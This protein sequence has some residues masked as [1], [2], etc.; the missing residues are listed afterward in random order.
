MVHGKVLAIKGLMTFGIL[1]LILGLMFSMSLTNVLITT[2]ALTVISY[3]VG[4]LY[5]LPKTNNVIASL[6][7]IGIAFLVIW[8]LSMGIS[9]LGIGTLA[10]GAIIASVV[11]AVG[12]FFF[13]DYLL[14]NYIGFDRKYTYSPNH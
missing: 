2:I 12:E 3:L 7:D 11:L 13:H 4:D 10:G 9:S 6:S 8:L 14:R 5:I 1:L